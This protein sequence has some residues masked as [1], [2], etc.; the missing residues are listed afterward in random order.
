[1]IFLISKIISFFIEP[2]V[3]ITLLLL[4][5]KLIRH[6]IWKKRC[7]RMALG[8]FIIFTNSWLMNVVW[9]KYQWQ[10]VDIES[11]PAS[12][13][14]ILLGGMSGYDDAMKKGF[15]GPASDRFIQMSRLY[16]EGK[17]RNIIVTGG[18]A[19]FVKEQSYSEAEFLVQNFEDL[20]IPKE[21]LFKETKAR[22]TLQNASFTKQMLDSMHLKGPYILVTS[23]VHMPRAMKVFEK[24]GVPVIPFP[25]NYV[26]T[27]NDTRFTPIK[28]IPSAYPLLHWG[29]LLREW[30]GLVQLK[31]VG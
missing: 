27:Q 16:D 15:F 26:V 1:M 9:N 22:N 29:S 13:A 20:N 4:T 12:D 21:H 14:G 30:M 10:P 17:I 18:N 11:L 19:I 24:A 7:Y 31:L 8:V 28:L 5:G 3:W 6:S 2:I 23:A 25:S